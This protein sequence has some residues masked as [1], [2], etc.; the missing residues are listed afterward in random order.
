MGKLKMRD[1]GSSVEDAVDSAISDMNEI[2]DELQSWYDNLPENFQSGDKGD[3]L[4]TAIDAISSVNEPSAPEAAS[5]LDCT[6]QEYTGK[7]GRPKRRDNNVAALR[8]AADAVRARV[9]ELGMLTFEEPDDEDQDEEEGEAAIDA[10]EK[11]E[12]DKTSDDPT[13]ED[14]RDTMVDELESY[15]DDIESAADE[16]ENVEFPGMY[17]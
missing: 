2:G 5:S 16:Y 12:A 17:G 3:Q 7:F 10:E 8:S 11:H 4:Q 13:T 9:E 15:A 1:T 6:W 14:E